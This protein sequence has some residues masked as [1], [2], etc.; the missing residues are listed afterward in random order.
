MFAQTVAGIMKA[1]EF[2]TSNPRRTLLMKKSFISAVGLALALCWP[3][4]SQGQAFRLTGGRS[5]PHINSA[6]TLPRGQFMLHTFGSSSYQTVVVSRNGTPTANTFWN[7]QAAAGLS[8]ASGKHLEWALTQVIYQDTHRG[9]GY[10]VPD[11]LYLNM[12]FGSFGSKVSP[13]KAGFSLSSRIPLG[14]NHNILFEPY[15]GGG[16]ELGVVGMASYSPDLLLPENAFNMHVNLGFWHH[17]DLGKR[18]T[19]AANDTIAVRQSSQEFLWG[20][21]FAIPTTQFDFSFELYG[22]MFTVKPPVTAYAREDFIYFSPAVNY[23]PKHWLGLNVGFDFRLTSD[24]DQTQYLDLPIINKDLANYPSWRVNFGAK[25]HLNQTAPPD[26]R[27]L[28]IT[29]NG[30]LVPRQKSL[31]NQLDLEQKKTETAE[32]ELEKIRDERKR[33]EVMLLRLR[34][35][36]YNNASADPNAVE[37]AGKNDAPQP[38]E[39]K[40]EKEKPQEQQ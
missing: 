1:F 2:K 18:L 28:F 12:K 32:E 35:L 7:V 3:A 31:E 23:R 6:F 40:P 25:F 17:N 39:G 27:P 37:P 36:L 10:N 15:S 20:A 26:N 14:E 19:G 16:I 22:R 9:E 33:M 34:H 21:G 13:L 30:R 5:L 24:K 29:S 11:D 38:P 4:A 8:F